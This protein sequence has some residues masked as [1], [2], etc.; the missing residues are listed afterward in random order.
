MGAKIL[1]F[2]ELELD[3]TEAKELSDAVKAYA[4]FK[5]PKFLSPEKMALGV[6][7]A[8]IVS[9]YGTRIAVA[10][11]K[12]KDKP[13]FVRDKVTPIDRGGEQRAATPEGGR[14]TPPDLSKVPPSAL[15]DFAPQESNS[16]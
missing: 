1:A 10:I 3:A 7:L 13:R 8:A 2:D 4:Q 11:K 12:R 15:F 5:T 16:Y 6:L 9:I 14:D